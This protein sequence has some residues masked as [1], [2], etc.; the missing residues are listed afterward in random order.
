MATFDPTKLS[1]SQAFG[2]SAVPQILQMGSLPPR[3]REE[4]WHFLQEFSIGGP[5]WKDIWY[6]IFRSAHSE[7]FGNAGNLDM[8]NISNL[9]DEYKTFLLCAPFN[10][11]FDLLVFLMR[12]KHCPR[13][14]ISRIGDIFQKNN[15]AYEL[16]GSELPTICPAATPQEGE[17]IREALQTLRYPDF[18]GALKHLEEAVLCANKSDWVGS[19]RE[20]IHAV[21]SVARDI[22]SSGDKKSEKVL[23]KALNSLGNKGILHA[24]LVQAFK[25]LYGYA[26]KPGIRHGRPAEDT[27]NVGRDEALLILGVCASF[28][29]YLCRKQPALQGED[30][31]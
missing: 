21:E 20:S 14:F 8:S 25:K 23:G 7:F 22:E 27:L 15:L 5:Y 3:V 29:S 26:S 31:G 30:D 24:N 19:I 2:Y 10:E 18:S 1:F 13:P 17:A 4:I 9:K 6:P 11:V 12:S 16:T 28:A